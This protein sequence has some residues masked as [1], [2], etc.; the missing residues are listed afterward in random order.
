M[1]SS[2]RRKTRFLALGSLSNFMASIHSRVDRSLFVMALAAM[3]FALWLSFSRMFSSQASSLLGQT[4]HP[5]A[6]TFLAATIF[7]A[8]SSSRAAAIQP[9]ACFGFVLMTDSRSTRT[10]LMSPT[11]ASPVLISDFDKLVKYPLG[12]ILVEVPAVESVPDPNAA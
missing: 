4:S 11:S 9:G 7:P 5:L 10:R 3:I 6:M 8:T 12:S 1:M 2:A